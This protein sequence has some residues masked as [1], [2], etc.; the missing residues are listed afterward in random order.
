MWLALLDEFTS[1]K[2]R[3]I[4]LINKSTDIT[5]HKCRKSCFK[6]LTMILEH[7]VPLLDSYFVTVDYDSYKSFILSYLSF[8]VYLSESILSSLIFFFLLNQMRMSNNSIRLD[9]VHTV[10]MFHS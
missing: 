4:L 1:N 5:F 3:D 9:T 8:H 7:I 6:T 10:D 2:E